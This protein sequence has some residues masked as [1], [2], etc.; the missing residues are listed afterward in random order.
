[1][2]KNNN[3]TTNK[4]ILIVLSVLFFS[5]V[6]LHHQENRLIKQKLVELRKSKED[7]LQQLENLGITKED[8]EKRRYIEESA[9]IDTVEK[10]KQSVVSIIASK[11]LPKYRNQGLFNDNFFFNSPFDDFFQ[12]PFFYQQRQPRNNSENSEQEQETE[13][14][15]IGGGSGFIYSDD[16]L[17]LTNRHVVSDTDAQYT[18][19]LYDGT[20]LESEILARDNFNDLAV[21]K[22]KNPKNIK[23]QAIQLGN[24]KDLKVGQR[25]VAIGNAL[26]EFENTVTTGIISA[27][28]RS[29]T[30]SDGFSGS[31]KI[32]NLLQTD[33]AINPGNSGGPLVNLN[34]EVIGVNTA[35]A[36]NANGIGFA[37]PINDV[38]IVAE[39]VA[40]HGKLVRPFMGIRYLMINENLAKKLDLNSNKGA[41]I[42]GDQENPGVVSDS[43]AKKS[44]LKE[45]DIILEINN[46]EITEDYDIRRAIANHNVGDEIVLKILRDEEEIEIKII[47]G[48]SK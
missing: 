26:A 28:G 35:I 12:N 4:I 27:S 18:I 46:E 11:D 39:T 20:E 43:P 24:S 34:G 8:L 14:V 33:A 21:L 36:Q 5:F 17:I 32:S 30:A 6:F 25:V 13:T 37:I 7:I 44:G 41:L 40:K 45:G 31:E 9:I 22:V 1:M 48:E 2:A 15:K 10:V 3:Q 16:G 47:L 19:V 38:K 42:R 23:L 29:I